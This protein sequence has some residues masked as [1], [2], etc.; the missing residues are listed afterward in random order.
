MTSGLTYYTGYNLVVHTKCLK[1]AFLD[2]EA[3]FTEVKQV[4]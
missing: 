4:R 1:G 3:K 2:F